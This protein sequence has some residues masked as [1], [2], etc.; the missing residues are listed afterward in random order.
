MSQF[1]KAASGPLVAAALLASPALAQDQEALVRQS[2]I[3]FVG[4][5]MEVGGTATAAIPPE[6]DMVVVR[7]E[8]VLDKPPAVS[9]AAEQSVMVKL[10]QA[11]RLNAGDRA[12]FYTNGRIFADTLAVEEVGHEP[13]E[14]QAAISAAGAGPPNQ[15]SPE[16]IERLRGNVN[17]QALQSRIQSAA[18]V[19]AGRVREIREPTG[20]AAQAGP[21]GGLPISEHNPQIAEAVI[22]VTE[23]IKGAQT[24][25]QVVARFPTSED[26]MWFNYPK[27]RVGETGVFI[28]QP[29][30]LG[31]GGPASLGAAQVPAFN[32]PQAGDVLPPGSE[33]QVR[34][35]APAR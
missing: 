22:E 33:D 15:P 25:S 11:G 23:G 6:P 18:A 21:G 29:D 3:I 10:R 17:D 31:G 34:S 1:V 20:T 5:V 13:L 4:R 28:L 35:L 30:T 24:G 2:S 14:A 8:R 27:F 26:V 9:I 12:V 19:V 7:V 16:A 32:A